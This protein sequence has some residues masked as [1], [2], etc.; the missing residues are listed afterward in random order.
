MYSLLSDSESSWSI[1]EVPGRALEEVPWTSETQYG[2]VFVLQSDLDQMFRAYLLRDNIVVSKYEGPLSS[3]DEF[4]DAVHL[5]WANSEAQGAFLWQAKPLSGSL[6][7]EPPDP[8]GGIAVYVLAVESNAAM[9]H[10]VFVD[11]VSLVCGT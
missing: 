8:S 10:D 1:Y 9:T 6:P 2:S 7:G 5:W 11:T 3:Y 4:V